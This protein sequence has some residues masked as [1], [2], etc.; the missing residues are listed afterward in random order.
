MGLSAGELDVALKA[1]D[2]ISP[3]VGGVGKNVGGL[4]GTV[5]RF[6]GLFVGAFAVAAVAAVGKFAKSSYDYFKNTGAAIMDFTRLTGASVAQSSLMLN[7]A[8]RFGVD[9]SAMTNS[10][11]FLTKNIQG[12]LD[13]SKP[14]TLAFGRLGLS[15]QFIK[16][17]SPVDTFMKARDAL[18]KMTN[19]NMR[20]AASSAIFG[21]GYMGLLK[22]ITKTP[23]EVKEAT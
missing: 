21:R 17:H 19:V 3:V 22:L 20:N 2:G 16:S 8:K 4:M 13:G 11:K 1:K 15:M 7:L 6:K 23:K 9:G 5:S 12:A 10:F 18:S 14:L